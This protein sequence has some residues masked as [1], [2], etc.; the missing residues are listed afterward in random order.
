M[1][2]LQGDTRDLTDI[3]APHPAE[4]ALPASEVETAIRRRGA[5]WIITGA[6]LIV[7]DIIGVL[8]TAILVDHLD[9]VIAL[10]ICVGA[11][12]P[13]TA[14]GALLTAGTIEWTQRPTR[15][16]IRAAMARAEVNGET[17]EGT[18]QRVDG[19]TAEVGQ[20]RRQAE[21]QHVTMATM[22]AALDMIASYLP[23]NQEIHNWRG[24]SA[25]VRERLATGADSQQW[26]QGRLGLVKNDGPQG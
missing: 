13:L 22:A 2:G 1:T 20:L 7:A 3:G 8:T 6:S 4:R 24:F 15:T 25:A 26:N 10:L 23:E 16:L 18:R 14:G 5:Q 17:A 9:P 21:E 19:L 11:M 12:L